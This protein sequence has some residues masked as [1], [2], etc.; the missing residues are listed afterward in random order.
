MVVGA[1]GIY[2]H[3]Q[4]PHVMGINIPSK[5]NAFDVWLLSATGDTKI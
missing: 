5:E 1:L 4:F 2:S 3:A